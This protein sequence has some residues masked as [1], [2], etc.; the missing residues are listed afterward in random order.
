MQC[1]YIYIYICTINYWGDK[2]SQA[3][4]TMIYRCIWRWNPRWTRCQTLTTHCCICGQPPKPIV[5]NQHVSTCPNQL[6]SATPAGA[7]NTRCSIALLSTLLVS[8]L[9][10][11]LANLRYPANEVYLKLLS[12]CNFG[13]NKLALFVFQWSQAVCL[14]AGSLFP[15]RSCGVVQ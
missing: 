1:A 8:I 4:N 6:Q 11:R 2:Q 15:R 14:T 7:W 12:G 9:H 10:C 13:L 5:P 3:W